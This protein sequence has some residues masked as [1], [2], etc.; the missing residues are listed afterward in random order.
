M[1]ILLAI[2]WYLSLLTP[3]NYYEQA[4]IYQIAV[5]NSNSVDYFVDNHLTEAIDYYNT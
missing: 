2:V 1:E 3:G 4:D 5:D